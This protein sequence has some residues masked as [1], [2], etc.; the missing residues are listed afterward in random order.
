MIK[1]LTNDKIGFVG[2]VNI[3]IVLKNSSGGVL[4][5]FAKIPYSLF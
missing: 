5:F 3:V 1:L 4:S 2:L